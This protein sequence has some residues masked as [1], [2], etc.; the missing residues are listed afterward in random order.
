MSNKPW[1][2]RFF[3]KDYLR[4]YEPF[5]TPEKTAREVSAITD[6]LNLPPGSTILDLCCGYGRHT[7]PLAQLGYQMTGLDINEEFLQRGRQ[8][9]EEENLLIHWI[10]SDMRQIPAH[11]EFDAIINI[12]TSFGYL[13]SEEENQK[14]LEQVQHALKPDGLFLLET[15]YQPR[16]LRAFTP[17]GI[18]HYDDGLIV[19]EER[20]IDLFSSRNEVHITMF[21]PDG[22]RSEQRQSIRIY[23]L[24]ELARMLNAA[25]MRLLAYYGGLDGSP[26]T[27]DSRLVVLSQKI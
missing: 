4:I 24:S 23:T 19:V 21:F 13:A 3:G 2:E 17:H 18:T 15:V 6:L 10:R 20:R 11:Q 25:G 22:R 7:L 26:L 14:V 1:Y 8:A 16:V 12:F 27:L 9:A 5:L